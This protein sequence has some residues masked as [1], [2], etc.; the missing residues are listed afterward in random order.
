MQALFHPNNA[1]F[2]ELLENGAADSSIISF[3]AQDIS[4]VIPQINAQLPERDGHKFLPFIFRFKIIQK[5][6]LERVN[7]LK[8]GAISPSWLCYE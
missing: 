3:F 1:R 2:L 7:L 4:K 5:G 6:L 8:S